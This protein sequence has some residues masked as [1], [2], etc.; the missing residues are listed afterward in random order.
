MRS[1]LTAPGGHG[2]KGEYLRERSDVA[3]SHIHFRDSRFLAPRTRLNRF[4]EI[5]G[6]EGPP[7]LVRPVHFGELNTQKLILCGLSENLRAVLGSE[8]PIKTPAFSPRQATS[9]ASRLT[10]PGGRGSK[11]LEFAIVHSASRLLAMHARSLSRRTQRRR[12]R[13]RPI[14]QG[15]QEHE[16]VGRHSKD[17]GIPKFRTKGPSG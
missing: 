1:K 7:R 3:L 6:M 9:T 17:K 8:A 4:S 10:A 12:H 15:R 14:E 11:D 16:D 5:S 13:R 2:S